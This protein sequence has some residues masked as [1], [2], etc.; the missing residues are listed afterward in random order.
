MLSNDVVCFLLFFFAAN[1]PKEVT[2]SNFKYSKGLQLDEQQ[3]PQLQDCSLLLL[4]QL[5][6][7]S[8]PIYSTALAH[9]IFYSNINPSSH[10]S[11]SCYYSPETTNQFY[12][13]FNV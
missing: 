4:E 11:F 5:G 2:Q 12:S 9:P 1:Y 7:L 6:T 13:H 10:F 3:E 8:P